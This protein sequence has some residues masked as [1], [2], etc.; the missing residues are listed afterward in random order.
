M[1]AHVDKGIDLLCTR[2]QFTM[3]PFVYAKGMQRAEH[4]TNMLNEF[5]GICACAFIYTFY[6][7][8][9]VIVAGN[10]EMDVCR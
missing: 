8:N 1:R 9:D 4:L 7:F 2:T 5:Y 10:V 3:F 6:Y